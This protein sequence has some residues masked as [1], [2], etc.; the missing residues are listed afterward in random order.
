M[1][2]KI[3]DLMIDVMPGGGA[4]R[5]ADTTQP[6]PGTLCG[7]PTCNEPPQCPPPSCKPP[8]RHDPPGGPKPPE[9]RTAPAGLLRLRQELRQ[10][11]AQ[12]R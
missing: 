5:W 3:Q 6:P 11:L 1:A 9:A 7:N 10:T 4:I 8:S 12:G 2:F